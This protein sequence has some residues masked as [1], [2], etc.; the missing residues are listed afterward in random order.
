MI[1]IITGG[2][3]T[4]KGTRSKI[5]SNF[6]NIPH[7]STGELLRNEAKVNEKIA[8]KL[9][10]GELITDELITK[11]LYDRITKK[12][13]ENGFILDGY[14][15]T[16]SQIELLDN[17]F[18]K[19][20]VKLDKV[21]ELVIDDELAFKR[22]LE[23][24]VCKKCKKAYGIDFPPVNK[25]ICDVCGGELVVRTDDTEEILAK[26]IATYKKNSKKILEHYNKIGLLKTIDASDHPEKIIEEVK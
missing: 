2:P 22:I 7:I 11:I 24:Q 9:S 25:G 1:Y 19:I 14:P 21:I 4:G 15:R 13:C 10:N 26:R 5:L 18:E 12:D 6:F 17:M 16:F 23:R 20:G 8:K 3:A